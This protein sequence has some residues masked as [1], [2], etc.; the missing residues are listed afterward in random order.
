[1]ESLKGKTGFVFLMAD[2]TTYTA[3]EINAQGKGDVRLIEMDEGE[4]K[5]L[6]EGKGVVVSL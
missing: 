5:V 6:D 2:E 3:V 1:L 4:G